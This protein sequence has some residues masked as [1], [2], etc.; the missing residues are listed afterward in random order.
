M[1]MRTLSLILALLLPQLL[2]GQSESDSARQAEMT[3][4]YM[5]LMQPG[6]EHKLLQEL[7]GEWTQEVKI[8]MAPGQEPM[9]FAGTATAEMIL[10]GRF[11]EFKFVSGEGMFA[12]EGLNILGFDRR[13]KVYTS[14]GF[15]T[16]GTYFVTA[17]GNYD[18][19]AKSL[20]LFG[21]AEDRTRSM[22]EKYN[23]VLKF[24]DADTFIWEV[25]FL[26][27]QQMYGVD[28]FRM[29]EVTHHRVK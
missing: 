25:T 21:E 22:T 29:V 11:L 20:S 19:A 18:E 15:D 1:R 12:G 27:A 14:V 10:G 4:A 5:E 3:Q 23:I 2:I 8:W 24:L 26:E 7:A 28:E 16:W 17:E 13:N 6:P 9:S